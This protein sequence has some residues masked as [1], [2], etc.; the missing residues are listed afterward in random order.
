MILVA[1]FIGAILVVAAI[2][3]T[4]G[5]LFSALSVDVPAFVVWAAA[6]LAIGALGFLP[7]MKPVSRGLLALILVVIVLRNYQAILKGFTTVSVSQTAN[8]PS[9]VSEGGSAPAG[10]VIMMPQSY[11]PTAGFSG[12]GVEH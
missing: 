5:S 11:D 10:H 3:N 12:A 2:R 9:P 4:Y 8:K 7:G 1:L 6:I